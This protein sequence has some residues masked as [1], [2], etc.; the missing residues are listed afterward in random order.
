MA[1]RTFVINDK[2]TALDLNVGY[3]AVNRSPLGGPDR[4]FKF[5]VSVFF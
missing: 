2:G 4:Q 5:G 1:G 3:Y